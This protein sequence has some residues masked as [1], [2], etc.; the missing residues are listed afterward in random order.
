MPDNDFGENDYSNWKGSKRYR[1]YYKK[2][3][4]NN[5][6]IFIP[7]KSIKIDLSL[8]R[9]I[10][11]YTGIVFDIYQTVGA[12]PLVIGGGGRYD[13]LVKAFGGKD[14]PAIGFAYNLDSINI[15]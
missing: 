10:S 3:S 5:Y 6:E 14:V 13:S 12:K 1:P 7:E 9:G 4:K 2:T 11:Y 15:N 8:A